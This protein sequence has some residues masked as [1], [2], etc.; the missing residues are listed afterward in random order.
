MDARL[1]FLFL[2]LGGSCAL[3]QQIQGNVTDATNLQPLVGALIISP[4]DT[5]ITDQNGRFL[6]QSHT[7]PSTLTIRFL[8]YNP[9]EVTVRTA[10]GP[11]RIRLTPSNIRLNEVVVS[12]GSQTDRIRNTVG[13]IS[14]IGKEMLL[15]DDPFSITSSINR[16]PGVY[17]HSATYTTNRITIR[18]IGSRSLYGTN[19][20]KAYYD[21]IPLT[22]GSGNSTIEDI[23]QALI[24]RIEAIKG[25]NSSLYGAGLA[26]VIRLHSYQPE[27]NRT[28]LE[29]SLTYGSYHTSRLMNRFAH[30]DENTSIALI[31]TDM[32]S[33]GYRE[34]S[35]YDRSQ[36]GITSRFYLDE[37]SSISFLGV[38]TKLKAYIPSSIN[39]E[40][41]LNHPKKAAFNWAQARGFEQYAK[42]LFGI[43]YLTEIAPLWELSASVFYK[44]QD[45][46]EPT[47]VGGQGILDENTAS[48]GT[49][50]TIT[51][52][53]EQLTLTAG[54]ELFLD[55]YEWSYYE[56]LYNDTTNGSVL[57]PV[58]SINEEERSNS[59]FFL[60]G[61]YRPTGKLSLVAG[62]NFNHTRYILKDKF[63]EDSLDQSGDYSF[64][65]MLSPRLGLSYEIHPQSNI[66]MNIS[67]GFSPPALDET[68]RPD[69]LVNPNIQP[70]TGWNFESGVRGD[71]HRLSYDLS[72]YLMSIQNLIVAERVGE[73]QY[74]GVNAGLNT[75]IG[76]DFYTNYFIPLNKNTLLNFFNSLS[77]M[78]YRFTDFTHEDVDYS[79][80]QLTGV[81]KLMINP[82]V[83]LVNEN[84]L[85]GNLT[86]QYI[87]KIPVTDANN[88]YT[89]AYLVLR[90]KAGYRFRIQRW[91]FD[92]NAG[93]NNVTN[94]HYASMLL[95]NAQGFDGAPPRFYYPGNPR[96]YF[97]GISI[98][99]SF[100]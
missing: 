74:I 11:V 87:G 51:R 29:S 66:Y 79:G 73:N 32:H 14:L 22:D 71:H 63:V 69:G 78:N 3:S 24:G 52:S 10:S 59:N 5:A 94:E 47:P 2:M 96:N 30:S 84:G 20:I 83:E 99:Y 50:T 26:G 82:G 37:N 28:S 93:V 19:K 7:L 57:G 36:I 23:D 76:A 44:N 21:Q 98:Q 89:D 75:H 42:S 58:F 95:I 46:Y 92:L 38:Y 16:I 40:D 31:H 18:G 55:N 97:G 62:M 100:P 60:E 68:L 90:A 25:P 61:A 6:L 27:S 45:S 64:H 72:I 4:A 67:H 54:A 70:E 33:D 43:S 80:N 9:E 65:K 77:W 1:P 53:S 49:R 88:L 85:Y 39:E 12:S 91:K 13:S 17:M 8:G 48:M 41:Y 86:G 81:P 34:N 15:R 56:N 35:A